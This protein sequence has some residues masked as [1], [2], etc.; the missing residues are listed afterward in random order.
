MTRPALFRHAP[1]KLFK[2]Y[3]LGVFARLDLALSTQRSSK[4]HPSS[5]LPRA[6]KMLLASLLAMILINL[7][8]PSV[9]QLPAVI[10]Y[11]LVSWV[12]LSVLVAFIRFAVASARCHVKVTILAGAH[13]LREQAKKN[14]L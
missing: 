8:I 3:L 9:A 7:A 10:W 13:H 14:P 11:L 1:S 2:L 6:G 12:C 4:P 5:A